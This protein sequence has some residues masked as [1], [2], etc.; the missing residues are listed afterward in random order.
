MRADHH[1]YAEKYQAKSQPTPPVQNAKAGHSYRAHLVPANANPA[2][3]EDLAD[4]NLLPTIRLR[5]A[6][7]TQ[8]EAHAHLA[9]G[10]GVLRVERVEG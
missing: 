8:A 7:A 9:S 4:A 1:H 5:A 10:K 6:N 3:L 2:D